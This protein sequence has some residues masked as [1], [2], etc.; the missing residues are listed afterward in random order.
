LYCRKLTDSIFSNNFCGAFFFYSV[1]CETAGLKTGTI[2]EINFA[3]LQVDAAADDSMRRRLT[4]V[5]M[6]L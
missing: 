5:V 6:G 3:P 2:Q 1:E 4:A